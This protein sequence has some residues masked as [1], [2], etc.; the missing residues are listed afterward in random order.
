METQVEHSENLETVFAKQQ[1]RLTKILVKH[2]QRLPNPVI[3]DLLKWKRG[4]L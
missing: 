1:E 4:E 2:N 3:E